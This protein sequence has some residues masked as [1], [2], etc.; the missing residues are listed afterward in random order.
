MQVGKSKNAFIGKIGWIKNALIGKNVKIN[1]AHRNEIPTLRYGMTMRSRAKK[2]G[3]GKC[4]ATTLSWCR[5]HCAL[6]AN[7]HPEPPTLGGGKRISTRKKF[8]HC[9]FA[10]GHAAVLA[11]RHA[12]RR[13]KGLD[14]A[15]AASGGFFEQRQACAQLH[16]II[17]GD[18]VWFV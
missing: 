12:V 16:L 5:R 14:E 7:R 11:L 8:I 18:D 13:D 9:D 15:A 4:N 6:M 2:G 17:L 10:L 3:D 1:F